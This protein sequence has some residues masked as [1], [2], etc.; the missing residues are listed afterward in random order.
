[1]WTLDEDGLRQFAV[2]V[3]TY[4]AQLRRA[5]IAA[6]IEAS[7]RLERFRAGEPA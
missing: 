6:I 5:P 2:V 7:A 4:D 3:G 1:V